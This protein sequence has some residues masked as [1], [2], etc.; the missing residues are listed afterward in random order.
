MN[1][2]ASGS[3]SQLQPDVDK[4]D[5]YEVKRSRRVPQIRFAGAQILNPAGPEDEADDGKGEKCV[6][7]QKEPGPTKDA[8]CLGDGAVLDWR[9]AARE[10]IEHPCHVHDQID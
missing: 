2:L 6:N 5:A 8:A 9:L 4:R 1:D 3:P 7:G 10:V